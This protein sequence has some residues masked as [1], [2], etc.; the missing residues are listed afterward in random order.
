MPNFIIELIV[1]KE[2]DAI[3]YRVKRFHADAL[4]YG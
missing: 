1:K 3:R 4:N 2:N